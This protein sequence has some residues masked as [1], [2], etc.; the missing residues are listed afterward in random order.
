M[1]MTIANDNC[2]GSVL[3]ELSV[4][5]CDGLALL[6]TDVSLSR[7]KPLVNDL[8]ISPLDL[9]RMASSMSAKI[10]EQS[11]PSCSLRMETPTFISNPVLIKSQ[12]FIMLHLT[13]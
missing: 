10:S 13:L 7:D 8:D 1:L 12:I 6:L 4:P 3:D 5:A 2:G 11:R 9:F